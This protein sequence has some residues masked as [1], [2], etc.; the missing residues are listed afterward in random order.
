MGLAASERATRGKEGTRN[1][2]ES[3]GGEYYVSARSCDGMGAMG[4]EL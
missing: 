1:L 2:V 4:D 3:E